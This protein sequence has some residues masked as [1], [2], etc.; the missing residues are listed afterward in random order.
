ME[1]DGYY[2]ATL[3]GIWTAGV[4][5]ADGHYYNTTLNMTDIGTNTNKAVV[6]QLVTRQDEVY[7]LYNRAGR[8]GYG[9]TVSVDCFI[10][11]DQAIAEFK[12]QF[13]E[14]TDVSWEQRFEE[15]SGKG[16]YN[17]IV[18]KTSLREHVEPLYIKLTPQ[19]HHLISLIY[20]AEQLSKFASDNRIDQ[21]KLPL[22]NLS[23]MQLDAAAEVL[24]RIK[25]TRPDDRATLMDLNSQFYTM[26]PTN[27]G[28]KA[29]KL[30]E[31]EADVMEKMEL[32][33][34]LHY[35]SYLGKSKDADP[36]TQYLRLDTKIEQVT[37]EATLSEIRAYLQV[38]HGNTHKISME[39]VNLYHLD[40]SHENESFKKY[41]NLHN[42][43][44]LWHGTNISNIVGILTSRFQIRGSTHGRMFGNGIYF[45]NSS[46]KS[47]NYISTNSA[48]IGFMFLCEVALG[49]CQRE[50]ASKHY[51]VAP[52]GTDSVHGEGKWQPSRETHI[53]KDDGLIIP[54]GELQQVNNTSSLFYDEFIVYDVDQIRMKY[55]L[56]LKIA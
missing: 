19:L 9:G 56:E 51:N 12:Q 1:A 41:V 2:P 46:S 35:I 15:K 32:L 13:Q 36:Y 42:R 29:P 3:S 52:M 33:E 18:T 38:N 45:A 11:K 4:Q 34:N 23:K 14:K 26:I 31:T 20:D 43:Q 27:S 44:L 17:F 22:G 25:E 54:I 10:N 37:D 24:N 39:L 5:D 47:G 16:K 21:R 55:L 28:S 49:T 40:K 7:F 48:G 8:V 30:I 50:M 53:I 6:M